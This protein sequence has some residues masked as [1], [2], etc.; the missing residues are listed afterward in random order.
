MNNARYI[1]LL[2]LLLVFVSVGGIKQAQAYSG[3]GAGTLEDPYLIANCV[4]LQ[5]MKDDITAHYVVADDIDCGDTENWNGGKGFE[6]VATSTPFTG[7]LDGDG[8]TITGLYIDRADDSFG[9]DPGDEWYVGL[10]GNAADATIQNL[11]LTNARIRGYR[12]VG[13][14]VGYASSTTF[15]NV[16]FNKDLPEDEC[17]PG[18]C[19]W[20]RYGEYGGGIVGY[21]TGVTIQNAEVGGSVKGSGVVIGGV[22]G[23]L[24]DSELHYA[25]TTAH[26][27]GG[28]DV[29][30]IVGNAQYSDI[31]HV[32]S[33]GSV[34]VQD[35]D[36]KTGYRGGGIA[37][38][39]FHVDLAYASS[40]S[41]VTGAYAL[42]GA[43][44]YAESSTIASTTASGFVA[45]GYHLGG[46]IGASVDSHITRSSAYGS[47]LGNYS[48][49][50]F[51]GYNEGNS[52]NSNVIS[53]SFAT[54]FILGNAEDAGGFVGTHALQSVI[55]DSYARGN[56]DGVEYVGNF[57]GTM[58]QMSL[59]YR[60]YGT[61]MVT[62][63]N[64]GNVFVGQS[65]AND[66]GPFLNFAD[67][68]SAST[69]GP[70]D[71]TFVTATTTSA[72]KTR[73]TFT[74][75][76]WDFTTIWNI[77]ENNDGYPI[78]RWQDGGN[79]GEEMV[80]EAPVLT[81]VRAIPERVTKSKAVLRFT[82][83]QSCEALAESPLST[84][85]DVESIISDITPGETLTATLRGI[86]VGG[87][88]SYSF[89]C[90]N[91]DELTSNTLTVGPFTVISDSSSGGR[92]SVARSSSAVQTSSVETSVPSA[93]TTPRV[94]FVQNLQKGMTGA[95][96][97]LLQQMLIQL[98]LGPAA[99]TLATF[100]ATGYFGAAT[101]AA[102][103]ELQK[104]AGI[105]PAI[106]YV[107]PKTRAY[108]N[109]R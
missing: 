57:V 50:G 80:G 79:D 19:V 99:R 91:S 87:T 94:P 6:P 33:S 26:I 105:A 34:V 55:T 25:T 38:N 42:G 108:L 35:D 92:S 54:G 21:A 97:Q 22:V 27:D 109:S 45:G 12:Y 18:Y 84:K 17:N 2:L 40:S 71:T 44:G 4:Q 101:Q 5:E 76:G 82:S 72:M 52:V 103:I 47:V 65:A 53:Q 83:N 32:R 85:G 62:G 29:G 68:Q 51:V 59:V 73:S 74:T 9:E 58:S 64:I 56:V 96:V 43:I 93:T 8:R 75:A 14:I 89:L 20:A 15:T 88:Y 28:N 106:G 102:V 48:V 81:L 1:V 100:G 31:S 46:F 95:N 77:N 41:D 7:S 63:N 107:G 69:T 11:A 67:L 60:S 24:D 90:V 78:L 16:S 39:L 66:S 98:N 23:Y 13:G 61:G 104:S 49:G 30:G 36:G 37:G 70:G 10:I 3:Q 86:Q